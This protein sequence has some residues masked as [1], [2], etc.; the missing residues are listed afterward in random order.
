MA[1]TFN[2]IDSFNTS[3]KPTSSYWQMPS[4]NQGAGEIAG[5][6]FPDFSGAVQGQRT[7]TQGLLGNQDYQTGNFL[8]NYSGAI[9]GQETMPAMYSRLST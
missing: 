6:K 9:A 1:T 7:A 3:T 2:P 8:K 5:Y 4:Y